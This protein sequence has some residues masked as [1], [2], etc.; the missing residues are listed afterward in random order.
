MPNDGTA[1]RKAWRWA[2]GVAGA[3]GLATALIG[4]L[5]TPWARPLLQRVGG[6][7]A[8][9]SPA[10]IEAAQVRAFRVLRG[11]GRAPARPSLGF[12]LGTATRAEVL[13][14][15][16]GHGLACESGRDGALLRCAGVPG[17]AVGEPGEGPLDDLSFGFRLA[18]ARLVNVTALRVGLDPAT[19]AERLEAAA[20]RL[21]AALGP[22][23]R[24]AIA[25]GAAG[26]SYLQY[27]YADYLADVTALSIPSQGHAVR[28]HYMSA[29]E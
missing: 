4:L 18:D 24:L 13:A 2:A 15:A 16:R 1:G 20:A 22:P 26:P 29:L 21:R 7:P 19:A 3:A 27:R 25:P 8:A 12:A 11:T 17:Q 28:E 5:H 9:R 14:W 10:A 6:C 23:A